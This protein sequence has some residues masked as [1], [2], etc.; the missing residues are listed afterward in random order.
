MLRIYIYI[1]HIH[2]ILWLLSYYLLIKILE[3]TVV[4]DMGSRNKYNS[5]YN[6]KN[7]KLQWD[8]QTYA[9]N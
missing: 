8:R 3:Y 2:I 1:D 4:I 5:I 9:N 7:P 6:G